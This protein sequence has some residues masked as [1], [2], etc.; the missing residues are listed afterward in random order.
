MPL[1]LL[2]MLL[3]FPRSV[4]VVYCLVALWCFIKLLILALGLANVVNEEG[5]EGFAQV[6]NVILVYK[7]FACNCLNQYKKKIKSGRVNC[8]WG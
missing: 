1:A 3:A 4:W 2:G 5:I 8:R 7:F 6:Q